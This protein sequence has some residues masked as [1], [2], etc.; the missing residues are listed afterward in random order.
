VAD[1]LCRSAARSA[2]HDVE[3]VF[4][5][6][7]VLAARREVE[8]SRNGQTLWR[9]PDD[10]R[11][12]EMRV[13]ALLGPVR[14]LRESFMPARDIPL[15]IGERLLARIQAAR[16]MGGPIGGT[17]WSALL[18]TDR[19][20]LWRPAWPPLIDRPVNVRLSELTRIDRGKLRD[21]FLYGGG[22]PRFGVSTRAGKRFVFYTPDADVVVGF[23]A[24]LE[25]QIGGLQA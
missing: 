15:E 25:A 13:D 18:L 14:W 5:E 20:L 7:V 23:L 22:V 19:R 9:L 11:V 12:V 4:G 6:Q 2:A 8:E 16:S 3:P 1:H 21:R 10:L 24:A 17:A